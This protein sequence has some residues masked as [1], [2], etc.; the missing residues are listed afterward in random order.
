MKALDKPPK[1]RS[2]YYPEYL[3]R[4]RWRLL[5]SDKLAWHLRRLLISE[6]R[7]Q[8]ALEPTY[9]SPRLRRR[10]IVVANR[11]VSIGGKV[12]PLVFERNIPNGRAWASRLEGV[13]TPTKWRWPG[14][15]HLVPFS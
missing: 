14:A 2:R 5:D 4:V 7:C 11:L 12:S 13:S 10:R 9:F 3:L 15:I 8:A 1:G 6:H